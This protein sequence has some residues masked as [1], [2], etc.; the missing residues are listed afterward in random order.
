MKKI[1]GKLIS[2]MLGA[3]V[4]FNAVN[5]L[6][7]LV[8]VPLF[9]AFWGVGLYGEWLVLRA[10]PAYLAVAEL[11]FSTSAANRMSVS[12]LADDKHSALV[13]FHSAFLLLVFVSVV[14]LLCMSALAYFDIRHLLN[15]SRE[16]DYHI[17]SAIVLMLFYAVLVFQSQLISA[18]YR[19]LSL[20]VSASHFTTHIRLLEFLVAALLLYMESGVVMVSLGYVAVRF[21]GIWAMWLWIFR[22]AEWLSYGF[23]C[24][25]LRQIRSMA[26][27]AAGFFALPLGQAISLQGAIFV[28]SAVMSPMAVVAFSVG[29]TLSRTLVQLGM[30]INRSV[31]PEMTRLYALGEKKEVGRLLSGAV[32]GFLLLSMSCGA[33]LL[34]G[35]AWFFDI[36]TAGKVEFNLPVFVVLVLTALINGFWFSM[37]TLLTSID[38]HSFVAFLYVVASV[39]SLV[40]AFFF[41][42][43][44]GILYIA[45][46][47]LVAEI[48]MVAIVMVFSLRILGVSIVD[49]GSD[50]LVCLRKLIVFLKERLLCGR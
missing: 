35:G 34:V 10:I 2:R 49:F 23:S 31:W 20:Y 50:V 3:Q 45:L 47:I 7:R 22:R 48:F 29:R 16:H 30:L 33:V 18:A 19:A 32:A 36:W 13:C 42:P 39:L 8:T 24:A 9:I 11:G 21:L 1:Q 15:F 40:A 26:P 14:L 41:A 44:G 4:Y 46:S 38:R 28:V 12:I 25:D 6:D 37:I 5:I 43:I 17:G 27:D